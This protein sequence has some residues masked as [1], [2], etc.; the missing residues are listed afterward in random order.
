[1]D[2]VKKD[3]PLYRHDI[4]LSIDTQ[5]G[6]WTHPD[7]KEVLISGI[8]QFFNKVADKWVFQLEWIKPEDAELYEDDEEIL[9]ECLD[10]NWHFQ[11]RV[12]L[13]E[14]KRCGTIV[15]ELE[16]FVT[17]YLDEYRDESFPF[18]RICIS[19]TNSNPKTKFDYV[20]K[21]DTRFDG[22]WSDAR[23]Y[24]GEDILENDK[25]YGWQ[26][27]IQDMSF[28]D[29]SL[30]NWYSSRK[31]HV[32]YDPTGGHGKSTL[33]KKL[34]Y[35][36]SEDVGFLSTFASQTQLSSSIV[37]CGIKNLY[38]IDLPRTGLSWLEY[39]ENGSKSTRKY[40]NRWSDMVEV[41][42]ILKN[43]G[44][45][46]DTMYG[47]SD[48]LIMKCPNIVIFTNWPLEKKKGDFFS[49]D[50]LQILE[51]THDNYDSLETVFNPVAVKDSV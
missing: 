50:R 32:I 1:M 13:K 4:T 15:R 11:C 36:R 16:D 42:E 44:P 43:G 45:I 34:A 51:L 18:Y 24:L 7:R 9:K 47:R 31:I 20:M 41:I 3:S 28:G 22:P 23:L 49:R 37:R 46:F 5:S 39:N 35:E 48:V 8:K 26:R 6:Q 30:L 21:S 27:D 12:N 29:E 2:K 14:R 33:V 38:I 17:D 25:M 10:L 40:S 19:P